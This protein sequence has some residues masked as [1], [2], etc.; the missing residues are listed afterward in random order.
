MSTRPAPE[1]PD[2][3]VPGA[4][5]VAVT[6]GDA[7]RNAPYRATAQTT[8][9]TVGAQFFTLTSHKGI[10]FGVRTQDHHGPGMCSSWIRVY[11]LDSDEARQALDDLRREKLIHYARVMCARCSN[12]KVVEAN[13]RRA[14]IRALQ[15]LD[16]YYTDREAKSQATKD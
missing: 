5:V 7:A 12:G 9:N 10:R 11:P 6:T 14:T 2:W 13:D 4:P 15:A 1:R 16:D 8:V 3:L